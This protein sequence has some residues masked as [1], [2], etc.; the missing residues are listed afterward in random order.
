MKLTIEEIERD[1]EEEIIVRCHEIDEDMMRMLQKLKK[2]R[3]GIVGMQ[4]DEI[5]R[6]SLD[7]IY[8]FEVVDNKSFFYCEEAV[9]ES[10]W[11][12]YEFAEVSRGGSFFR[13]SKSVI[14]NVDKIDFV[15]PAFSGRFEAILFNGEKVIVSRQY[16][17]ELK[18]LMGIR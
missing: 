3:N 9:Y 12:L 2:A 17:G 8:Y 11:K 18:E 13:A 15:K 14:L 16:V 4:G 10:K 5:H 1:K 7:E 6:L